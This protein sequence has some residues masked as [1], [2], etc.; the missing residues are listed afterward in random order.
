MSFI[1]DA[2]F[3]GAEKEAAKRQTESAERG[4]EAVQAATAQARRDAIPLFQG[5]QQNL[6][7]GFQG[8]LDVLGQSA[9]SQIGAFQQGNVGAQQQLLAGLPAQQAAILGGNIDLSSLQPQQI[10]LGD[11]SFLQQQLPQFQTINQALAV[12]KV[13]TP[14]TNINPFSFDN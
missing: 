10:N 12:P 14:N 5:G 2:F 9:P 4:I 11:L 7:A 1:T 8:A 6:L 3:G 13:S